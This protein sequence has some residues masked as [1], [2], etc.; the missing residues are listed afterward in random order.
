M[1]WIQ[2]TA[3]F[4]S[5]VQTE[6]PR[7]N[8]LHVY[9]ALSCYCRPHSGPRWALGNT[10]GKKWV[11]EARQSL[12]HWEVQEEKLKVHMGA[13]G[14]LALVVR[15]KSKGACGEQIDSPW[16]LQRCYVIR[17]NPGFIWDEAEEGCI[18]KTRFLL[19]DDSYS[20][21]G[22]QRLWGMARVKRGP[23]EEDVPQNGLVALIEM[24][25]DLDQNKAL[26]NQEWEILEY[27]GR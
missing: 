4:Q 5:D 3:C 13:T 22:L 26:G 19:A 20:R 27:R 25:S 7:L 2:Q 16:E 8:V 21:T 18:A 15:A 6:R 23:R 9:P 10:K 1:K 11:S 14:C 12:W 24:H 17:G